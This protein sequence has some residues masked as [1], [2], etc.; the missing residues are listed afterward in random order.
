MVDLSKTRLVIVLG[1]QFLSEELEAWA[2]QF[3]VVRYLRGFDREGAD[4]ARNAAIEEFLAAPEEW[5]VMANSHVLP[6]ER[7]A[8]L[9]ETREPIASVRCP[10]PKNGKK[11]REAHPDTF[12][13]LL[14]RAHRTV[15]ATMQRPGQPPWFGRDED[16]CPC[17]WF[18][19]RCIAEGF[20]PVKVGWAG[21]MMEDGTRYWLRSA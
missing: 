16:T 3:P 9:L 14:W 18:Y 10:G 12:S 7:T 6:D 19:D 21:R 4:E 15:L 1:N 17:R 11:V 20:R 13:A 8:P 5:L 2:S